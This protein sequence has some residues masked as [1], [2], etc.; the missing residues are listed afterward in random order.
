MAILNYEFKDKP[1]ASF[2]LDDT[3]I[4]T[5]SGRK[6]LVTRGLGLYL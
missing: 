3:I 4:K 2:D 6:V 1:F 5:K